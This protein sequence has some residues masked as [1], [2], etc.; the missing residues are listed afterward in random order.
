M[1]PMMRAR[2]SC[3]TKEDLR[4]RQKEQHIVR[5]CIGRS[6]ALSAIL[7]SAQRSSKSRHPPMR[8]AIICSILAGMYRARPSLEDTREFLLTSIENVLSAHSHSTLKLWYLLS[9]FMKPGGIVSCLCESHYSNSLLGLWLI[10]TDI[11]QV[12]L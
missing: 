1:L 8:S 2:I 3:L 6:H 4:K 10:Q 5:V 7:A 9:H 12:H 11:E